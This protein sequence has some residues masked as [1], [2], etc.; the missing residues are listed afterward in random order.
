MA[1]II[2]PKGK[3]PKRFNASIRTLIPTDTPHYHNFM[4]L[5]ITCDGISPRPH[6]RNMFIYLSRYEYESLKTQIK[7]LANGKGTEETAHN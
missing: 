2:L 6:G 3:M 7:E 1:I 4:E 5:K